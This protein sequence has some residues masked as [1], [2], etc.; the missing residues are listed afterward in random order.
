MLCRT[1][2]YCGAHLDPGESCNCSKK[3]ASTRIHSE[4]MKN[5]EEFYI[6]HLIAI[7]LKPVLHKALMDIYNTNQLNITY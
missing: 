5:N 7:R 4:V 6:K 1:C 3:E 2:P